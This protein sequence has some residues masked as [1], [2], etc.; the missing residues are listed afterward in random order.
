M[1]MGGDLGKHGYLRELL[2]LRE[3]RF[4]P[5]L[6][7]LQVGNNLIKAHLDLGEIE[8]ARKTLDQLYA[9]KR[10][11]YRQHLSFWNT[12]IAKA[13][14]ERTTVSDQPPLNVAI[15][16][17]DGPVWLK[18]SS[19]DTELFPLKLQDAPV[20]SFLGFS[21]EVPKKSQHVQLQIADAPGRMSRTLPLFVAEQV[22]FKTNAR[23]LT[24]APL[25]WA[26][27]VGLF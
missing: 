14:I 15:A 21:A 19:P 1:Q 13:G 27:P 23:V 2:E 8:P 16:T 24:L 9:L 4:V 25:V 10:P 11:D 12:E 18:P 26:S 6:H 20:I 7:G 5:Q 22:W 3:S 17:I